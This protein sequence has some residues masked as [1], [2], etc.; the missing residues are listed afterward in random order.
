MAYTEGASFSQFSQTTGFIRAIQVVTAYFKL[1]KP[2]IQIM[3]LFTA[4]CAMLIAQGSVPNW[5]ITLF[6]LVGLAL[7]SG[8]AA[9]I[10][11]WY[12]SD[13][14]AIMQ[15]TSKR[16]IPKGEISGTSSLIYGIGLIILSSFVLIIWV[17]PLTAL[18]SIMGAFYYAVIYTVWLKRRTPQNIVIGG[19]AGA[20]PPL[21]GWAAVTGHVSLESIMMFAIIF[22]WTPPHFWA[23]ALYKNDDYVRAGIPMMPVVRGVRSTKLQSIWYAGILTVTA[24]VM[25]VTSHVSIACTLI[26]ALINVVFF[27]LNIRLYFEP[28]TSMKWAKRTF[29]ASLAYLPAV[30]VIMVIKH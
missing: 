1:T 30:F 23:L 10:N 8:G 18:L 14:D 22:L 12:D 21:V 16:P 6:T 9:A 19:G 3:I 2:K 11:M 17:N 5:H 27:A 13:I 26:G 4:Y 20:I 15:R 29:V 28:E 7:S 24:I 25:L